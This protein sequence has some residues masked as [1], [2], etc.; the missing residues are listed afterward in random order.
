MGRPGSGKGAQSKLL[1]QK[2]GC[3][4]FSTGGHMREIAKRDSFFG[5]KIKEIVDSGG[6]T[7]YWFASFVFEEILFS[8][9][10]NEKVVFEGIGR[11]E[12]EARLFTEISEWLGRD[13]IVIYLDVSEKT[14]IERLKKR[15]LKE[16]RVDDNN[17]QNRLNNYN[18]DTI[19][20]IDFF[21]SIG[22]VIDI[23]GEPSPDAIA[24]LIWEKLSVL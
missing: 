9:E 16:G 2:L 4:V 15:R 18:T 24:N 1:A 3:K 19:H 13:F 22:K 11:K 5:R 8:L 17:V 21:R 23:D 7:P 14:I 20:A 12:A 10:G 6:L